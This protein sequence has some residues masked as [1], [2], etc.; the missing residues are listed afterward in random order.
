[1]IVYIHGFNSS[2]A[3]NTYGKLKKIFGETSALEY[4]SEGLFADNLALLCQ[5][6]ID[7]RTALVS[8]ERWQASQSGGFRTRT[9]CRQ[10]PRGS[11]GAGP[12]N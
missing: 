10:E 5:L 9:R 2:P 12:S 6:E 8:D 3:S 7:G 11:T 1:M 4:P